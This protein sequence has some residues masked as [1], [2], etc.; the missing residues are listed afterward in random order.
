MQETI[1][2]SAVGDVMMW[3][4]Q[5]AAAR[6]PDNRGYRFDRVLR[7]VAP[8]FRRSDLVIG[9][10]ET[11]F[12][13]PGV[14]HQLR[15]AK[16]GFP[17]FSCPDGLAGALKRA[18]FHVLT[19]ANNHCMDHGVAGVRRTLRVL[20]RY[21]LK[22]TGTARSLTEAKRLLVVPVK[23]IKV[24]I[25]AYTYGTNG[26]RPPALQRWTVNLIGVKAIR[27]DIKR[28]RSK[29]DL[30]VVAVH[31]GREFRKHPTEKQVRFVTQL[32]IAGADIVLG[33][34][35]HVVQ[36]AV[37]T[38]IR[39]SG[40]RP[41][42]CAAIFSLGNFVSKRMR[43]NRG[44]ERGLIMQITVGKEQTGRIELKS[45]KFIP[46]LTKARTEDQRPLYAVVPQTKTRAGY[47]TV[48]RS[49]ASVP[50]DRTVR[51]STG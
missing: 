14:A 3:R 33:S 13:G 26:I 21:G 48:Y 51:S 8:I 4:E 11:V 12:A 36:P 22:H 16:N 17:R 1:T 39:R 9:N 42:K 25:L 28:A 6:L 18:G 29:A 34:H 50:L 45:V 24:A 7:S 47:P 46:T 5:V 32:L 31:F 44:T 23:G 49:L 15:N 19:T 41:Q 30:V 2:L 10:L 43:N 40:A 27:T 37:V 20:D 38:R 35:P